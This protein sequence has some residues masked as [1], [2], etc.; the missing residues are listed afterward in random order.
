[1]IVVSSRPSPEHRDH[2]PG[3]AHLGCA[4][5]GWGA[6]N[7]AVSGL[8]GGEVDAEASLPTTMNTSRRLPMPTT[9]CLNPDVEARLDRLASRTGRSKA[10]Y[11]RHLIEE[12][13]DDLEDA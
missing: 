1:M 2:P 7:S 11:L 9:I 6:L 5:H 10:Y 3:T 13:L 8:P 12:H 4:R